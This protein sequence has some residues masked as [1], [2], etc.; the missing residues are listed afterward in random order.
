MRGPIDT[1]LPFH[2]T[3]ENNS[4]ILDEQVGDAL[5]CARQAADPTDRHRLLV[6]L[7]RR[8]VGAGNQ[9]IPNTTTTAPRARRVDLIIDPVNAAVQE[10]GLHATG[11]MLTA[12]GGLI[13]G[14]RL[15]ARHPLAAHRLEGYFP[16]N[17][18]AT[19]DIV[20]AVICSI[21][22]IVITTVTVPRLP[23]SILNLALVCVRR[24]A[25]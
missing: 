10:H 14:T 7:K 18:C 6:E 24:A 20:G 23:A 5:S 2:R 1:L 13:T 15:P 19:F 9:A 3:F 21:R 11:I 17:S 16:N 22:S 12:C 25:L 4:C 8:A